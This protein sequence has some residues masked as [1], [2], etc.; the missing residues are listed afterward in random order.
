[1]TAAVCA[2]LTLVPGA[3]SAQHDKPLAKAQTKG[4]L[5]GSPPEVTKIVAP[6]TVQQCEKFDVAIELAEPNATRVKVILGSFRKTYPAEGKKK[7]WIQLKATTTGKQKI[8]ALPIGPGGRGQRAEAILKVAPSGT[9]RYSVSV[10]A[11]AGGNQ[12]AAVGQPVTFVFKGTSGLTDDS[13]ALAWDFDNKNGANLSQPDGQRTLQASH[14][15][16]KTTVERT[17]GKE[18]MYTV[19]LWA[20][21]SLGCWD[22]NTVKVNVTKDGTSGTQ[23]STDE[24]P[25][26]ALEPG[27]IVNPPMT[28]ADDESRYSTK[29]TADAGGNQVVGVGQPASFLFKA[30]HA[31][32]DAAVTYYWDFDT[33]D[34]ASW[35]APD[36]QQTTSS[37]KVTATHTYTTTGMRT[38]ILW[39][40]DADG[41]WDDNT[42]KIN[43]VE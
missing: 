27:T 35:K 39:V 42:V 8:V 40:M 22:D 9:D 14:G 25:P 21:D 41:Y 13:I 12:M 26:E 10:Q 43:V 32:Q 30:T 23:A 5:L 7:L 4:E 34:G 2:G 36:G 29:V 1:V 17:Y 31:D 28:G 20:T 16:V 3:A 24:P 38:L 18:G 15:A 33:S 19:T 37:G 11:D 6:Q